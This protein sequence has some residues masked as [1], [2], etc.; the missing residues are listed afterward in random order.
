MSGV[1]IMPEK[2]LEKIK[3]MQFLLN[4]QMTQGQ[5][6]KIL[7]ITERQVPNVFKKYQE[8]GNKGVISKKIGKPTNHQLSENVNL[9]EDKSPYVK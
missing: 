7:N 4:K 6:A 2:D 1:I 5:A 3:I 8:F 9:E